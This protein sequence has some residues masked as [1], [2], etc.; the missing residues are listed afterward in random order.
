MLYSECITM[1][2]RAGKREKCVATCKPVLKDPRPLD[3]DIPAD[4]LIK[5]WEE[6]GMENRGCPPVCNKS[7]GHLEFPDHEQLPDRNIQE[8]ED[9]FL[10]ELYGEF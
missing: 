2:Q 8:F 7:P 6:N 4:Q 1:T 5:Y 10:E 3:L 9:R